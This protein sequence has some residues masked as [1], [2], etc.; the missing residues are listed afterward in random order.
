MTAT[1]VGEDGLPPLVANRFAMLGWLGGNPDRF[2]VR[3]RDRTSG[4]SVVLKLEKKPGLEGS[5]PLEYET[6]RKLSH[7]NI[8]S[9]IDVGHISR[10]S[11]V[12]IQSPTGPLPLADLVYLAT[13]D[14]GSSNMSP[15][16][17][18]GDTAES[19]AKHLATVALHLA[20]ALAHIHSR[21]LIHGDF[22]PANVVIGDNGNAS[23]I[24]FGLTSS[25]HDSGRA[26]GTAGFAAPEALI[27]VVSERADLFGLG[28]SLYFAWTGQ[29][30]FG[31]GPPGI[32]RLLKGSPPPSPSSIVAG[33]PQWLDDLILSFLAVR[34]EL[35]PKSALQVMGTILKWGADSQEQRLLSSMVPD[36]SP[37]WGD[38]LAG[39]FIGRH[40]EKSQ[41]VDQLKCLAAGEGKP[42]AIVLT[43]LPGSGRQTLWLESLAEFRRSSILQN[44]SRVDVVDAGSLLAALPVPTIADPGRVATSRRAQLFEAASSIAKLGPVC[45]LVS[46]TAAV[47]PQS[48]ADWESWNQLLSRVSAG[49]CLFV[50][51]SR[52]AVGSLSSNTIVQL[53]VDAFTPDEVESFCSAAGVPL[54]DQ[55]FRSGIVAAASGHAATVAMLLRRKFAGVLEQ[56]DQAGSPTDFLRKDLLSLPQNTLNAV[57]ASW[58]L[59]DPF[60]ERL[61]EA[62]IV[63]D[64]ED[65]TQRGWLK[66]AGKGRAEV[67]EGVQ[68]EVLWQSIAAGSNGGIS[69][70]ARLASQQLPEHSALRAEALRVCGNLD[71]AFVLFASLARQCWT[72][73]EYVDA[74]LLWQR[75]E[76]IGDLKEFPDTDVVSRAQ[77]IALLGDYVRSIDWIKRQPPSSSMKTIVLRAETRAWIA[78]RQGDLA[79]ASRILEELQASLAVETTSPDVRWATSRLS[80]QRA[81]LAVSA[82]RHQDALALA[83]TADGMDGDTHRLLLET[84]ALACAYLGRS[85]DS[86]SAIDELRSLQASAGALPIEGLTPLIPYGDE[87]VG[88]LWTICGILAQFQHDMVG[89]ESSYD[90]AIVAYEKI[91]DVHG[92]A[93]ARLNQAMAFAEQGR[94]KQALAAFA[95]A[96]DDLLRLGAYGDATA[97]AFNAG[98]LLARLGDSNAVSAARARLQQATGSVDSPVVTAWLE[99]LCATESWFRSDFVVAAQRHTKAALLFEANGDPLHAAL[100]WLSCSES[101]SSAGRNEAAV[102]AKE[103]AA[104]TI[105]KEALPHRWAEARI[106]LSGPTVG[107]RVLAAELSQRAI[108]DASKQLRPDAFRSALLAARLFEKDNDF[109]AS[110][111]CF[112]LA[113]R[114]QEEIKVHTPS[115]NIHALESDPD[116]AWL[117]QWR[118]RGSESTN[119]Q[120]ALL[121]LAEKLSLSQSRLKRFVRLSKRLNSEL[122]L[123]RLLETVLDTIIELTDAERGFVLLRDVQGALVVRAARNMDQTSIEGESLAFSRS[124]AEKVANSGSPIITVDAS[125]DARFRQALSVS[126]LQLRSVVAVPLTLKGQVEGTIYVDNRLR[127]GA[128]GDSDVATLLD[129]AEL[130]ALAVGNARL[131]SDLQRRDRHIETLNRKLEKEL[132]ARK[133]EIASMRVELSDSRESFALRF[134]Y[135]NIIGRSGR[136]MELLRILDRVSETNLP[137]IIQ[138]ESGTGKELVARALVANGPRKDKPFIAENCAAIPESLLES[139]LFGYNRGAFT[140]A[141]RDTRGLFSIAHEGT[142]FLDEVGEMSPGLQGKLLRVLQEGEFR[143]VGGQRT[144]RTDV[145]V[146][147][148]TNRDLQAMVDDGR[149]RQDLFFRLAVVRIALPPLRERSEDVPLLV[150]HFLELWK[151]RPGVRAQRISSDALARLCGYRWPGNIR[152][153]ENELARATAFSGETIEVSDLSP[154]IVSHSTSGEDG[155]SPAPDDLDL[156][157]RVERLEKGLLREALSKFEGNQT[158]AAAA[159]GLSRFGLQKKLRRYG[160][161]S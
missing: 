66:N 132:A 46:E 142:L 133:D 84:R 78:R 19:R 125:D 2:T 97:A 18:R 109:E 68:T 53:R 9:V 92:H 117:A 27:G 153:L 28:A 99:S 14:V 159:L 21:Q 123:P 126:D 43:G 11:Q 79:L 137:V 6:L 105:E 151:Q 154:H 135:K 90:Q 16:V 51:F 64:I 30:P 39:I 20:G 129:F 87:A 98:L 31:D 86:T 88:R 140:G 41:I 136:M 143:R 71:E 89:A 111:D 15:A 93:N 13:S 152:E 77:T 65:A 157:N 73:G 160:F 4:E 60:D 161:T 8:V 131:V 81:R 45:V 146:V 116:A 48:Q 42:H 3:A 141:E 10:D 33:L 29:A 124:I 155:S 113:A 128:F 134:D 110:R 25:A 63:C 61:V 54:E 114:M 127:Q 100:S 138:G 32:M 101:W 80:A 50:L 26:Q 49:P 22:T 12:V 75:A 115:Q 17:L 96:F 119:S 57:F 104:G 122:R 69:V 120:S 35:R 121:E 158:R 5:V 36:A 23:L 156:K 145:R 70:L 85:A 38:P 55:P 108:T 58:W 103:K 150:R 40:N 34:P 72:K 148:A 56:V 7:P 147:V 76:S 102:E 52:V 139:T 112:A 118:S 62:R 144:E 106:L 44:A 107:H 82:G 47:S 83:V 130:A 94:Y 1:K 24:D 59:I 67:P 91:G 95:R 74:E 149:F 37:S